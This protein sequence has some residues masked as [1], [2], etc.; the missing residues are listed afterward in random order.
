[1]SFGAKL[2]KHDVMTA[3][4][5]LDFAM[6]EILTIIWQQGGFRFVHKC[7]TSNMTY[8]Y[9]CSQDKAKEQTGHQKYRDV[10]R[11]E[12]FDCESKLQVRPCLESRTLFLSMRQNHHDAY[13]DKQL[14]EFIQERMKSSSPA[15]VFRDLQAS[16]T[17]GSNLATEH[18]IYYRYVY[19]FYYFE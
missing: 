8:H 12:R 10:A 4:E 6:K 13:V 18:Q 5:P 14:L 7:T 2:V 9:Y 11:M 15:E 16:A 1:M 17:P 3:N 19:K